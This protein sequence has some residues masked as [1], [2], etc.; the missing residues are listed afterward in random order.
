MDHVSCH[1]EK[2]TDYIEMMLIGY[3]K[4]VEERMSDGSSFVVHFSLFRVCRQRGLRKYSS[5][6][7]F[8]KYPHNSSSAGDLVG[9][10]PRSYSVLAGGSEGDTA[11]DAK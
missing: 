7:S 2:F 3:I 11:V 4:F 8:L 5:K 1:L 6:S 9:C 10:E